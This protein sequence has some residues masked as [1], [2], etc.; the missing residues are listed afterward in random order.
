MISLR[1]EDDGRRA[2]AR[3]YQDGFGGF[4]FGSGAARDAK[5]S[6]LSSSAPSSFVARKRMP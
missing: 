3:G 4:S 2:P 5:A 1:I 6:V